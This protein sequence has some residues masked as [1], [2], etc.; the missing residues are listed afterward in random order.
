MYDN[1]RLDRSLYNITGKSFTQALA[2]LDPDEG[3]KDTELRGL[4]AF[5]RQLKRFDIKVSGAESDRVEKFF[6]TAQS[7]VLFP[8]YVRRMIKKGLEKV[9]IA[10]AVCGAVSRTD[11]IAY[12]SFRIINMEEQVV[13]QGT[14]LPETY[15][16]LQDH[17]WDLK[18]CA[19]LLK[20]SYEAVRKHRLEAFGIILRDLG[21]NVGRR[22]NQYICTKLI[23]GVTP[24][25]TAGD[26]ITYAD[27]AKFWSDMSEYDMDVM[28]C[29][30]AVMAQIL[31][32]PEM[33]FC[34]SDYMKNGRIQTPY[35]VTLIKCSQMTENKI[36]GVDS[37]AAAELVLGSDVVVDQDKLI[38]TQMSE[39]SCSILAGIAKVSEGA[40]KVLN[41][42][43]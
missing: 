19:R 37:T 8:E 17:S 5:E 39:I 35:G 29:T 42:G 38:N 6:V 15:V 27:L 28:V 3:Y 24:S 16:Y 41:V 34:V 43:N 36:L 1:I 40:V 7:A 2:E 31:A 12:R 13:E 26:S 30:P 22:L 10:D 11:D 32:L 18:K 20:I 23:D 9:S 25:E 14:E 33:K 4:D 21:A